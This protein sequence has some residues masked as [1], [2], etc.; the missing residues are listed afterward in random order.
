MKKYDL[1]EWSILSMVLKYGRA[2][3]GLK[4]LCLDNDSMDS[5][6]TELGDFS[7]VTDENEDSSL[8][9]KLLGKE[10]LETTPNSDTAADSENSNKEDKSQDKK[11]DNK[12]SSLQEAKDVSYTEVTKPYDR[13]RPK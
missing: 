1:A 7:P 12:N 9:D 5:S 11:D 4:S 6:S 8:K 3:H 10:I 13:Y 2:G